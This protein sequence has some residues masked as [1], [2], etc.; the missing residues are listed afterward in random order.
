MADTRPT[1]VS[2]FQAVKLCLLL[3]FSVEKFKQE[4]AD[5]NENRKNNEP[6]S[7]PK[8]RGHVVRGAFL[9]SLLLVVASGAVGFVVGAIAPSFS[10]CAT[11]RL[12][13]WLQ[14]VGASLLLWG[15]LFVRG[16]DIQSYGG[17]TFTERVNQWLYRSL[18]CVGTAV[19]VC[20]L[21]W[22]QCPM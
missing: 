19:L 11:P 3:L 2:F 18:Y 6:P 22:S 9:S 14:I 10:S 21:V 20:S 17:V 13:A 7:E 8:Y 5:D 4:E 16:W 12:I 1:P 15:T